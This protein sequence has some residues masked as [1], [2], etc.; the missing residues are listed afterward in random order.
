MYTLVSG[1]FHLLS[2]LPWRLLYLIGD[3]IYVLLYYVFGY[4]KK[5]VAANLLI[6]FPEKT[7]AERKQIEKKILSQFC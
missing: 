5:V 6:A 3:G 1:L 7:A 2:R 4:R